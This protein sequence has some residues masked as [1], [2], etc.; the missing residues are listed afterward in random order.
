MVGILVPAAPTTRVARSGH[1]RLSGRNGRPPRGIG[2]TFCGKG[3]REHSRRPFPRTG[4]GPRRGGGPWLRERRGPTADRPR[5]PTSD[6][7]AGTRR[8]GDPRR[9]RRAPP[10]RAHRC[11]RAGDVL[12]GHLPVRPGPSGEPA[13]V[14]DAP[15]RGRRA[16]PTG[17]TRATPPRVGRLRPLLEGAARRR[18]SV[19]GAHRATPGRR[20]GPGGL[21]RLV[22]DALQGAR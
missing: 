8:L 14:P 18:P 16:A 4:A 20:T 7:L 17:R 19:R 10:P 12:L 6:G 5:S 22:V 3:V 1:G 13:G 9:G 2:R 11:R 21:P 15:L